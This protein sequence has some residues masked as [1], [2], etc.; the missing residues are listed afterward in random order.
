MDDGTVRSFPA[1]RVQHSSVLGPTKGGVRYDA[2]RQPRRVRR[3]R[4]VDDLEVR[5]AAPALRRREGRRALQPAGALARRA[6]ARHAPVHRRPR[7]RS[8]ARKLDI[9][10]PDMAT[11][12]QTMAWMMDTYS[13]QKGYAVPEIVTGKPVSI[14]GS[15][16]RH[17]ATGAG[18]V[19]VIERACAR[20]GWHLAEL[21]CV[22]QGFGNVGG[23]RRDRARTRRAPTVVGVSD[24]AGGDR[25]A[26]TASTCRRSTSTSREH[27]HARGLPRRARDLERGAARA[28]VRRARARRARGSG[29]GRERGQ[30]ALPARRRGRERADVGRGRRD[31]RRA[32]HP[33]PARRAHERRRRHRLVLRVGAG[34]RPAA[35][36]TATRSAAGWRRSSATRSTASGALSEQRRRCR[37]ATRR[38]SPASARSPRRSRRGGCTRERERRRPAGARR[39]GDRAARARRLGDGAGGGRGAGAARGARRVRAATGGGSPA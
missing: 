7:A 39:D 13:V 26:R 19:M 21:R 28:R 17:E 22:V 23:D 6:L 5:A 4:D 3:A 34:S 35:S 30:P 32:R 11:N 18:V 1:Y 9:P 10:A 20:L 37:C 15:L 31:P 24:V 36:G 27:G 33:R 16:F 12:E 25:R 8:S 38:S 29:D 14:G 2:R